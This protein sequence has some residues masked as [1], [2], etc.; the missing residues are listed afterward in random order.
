MPLKRPDPSN[1][2]TVERNSD[3][4]P[5]TAEDIRVGNT[6]YIFT[7]N[8]AKGLAQEHLIRDRVLSPRDKYGRP[9]SGTS[10]DETLEQFRDYN[11]FLKNRLA[12]GQMLILKK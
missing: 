5:A 3:M 1:P 7:E 10:N 6:V 2:Y 9:M 11:E 4:V 12:K 8:T